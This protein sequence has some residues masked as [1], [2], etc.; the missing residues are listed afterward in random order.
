[1]AVH[2]KHTAESPR[3]L[4]LQD[5]VGRQVR[6]K[7]HRVIGRLEEV[8]VKLNGRHYVVSEYVIGPAAV[9][10]RLG[11]RVRSLFGRSAAGYVARWDQLELGDG[12]HPSLIGTVED[13]ERID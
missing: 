4:R 10:E 3:A 9:F 5:L 11:L 13:L 2:R 7:H 1:M 12:E 6:D 8:R